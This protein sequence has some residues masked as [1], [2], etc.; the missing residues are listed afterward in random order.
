MKLLRRWLWRVL[1]FGTWRRVFWQKFTDS[2]LTVFIDFLRLIFD[3]ED[4]LERSSDTPT[5]VHVIDS[6][7]V[8]LYMW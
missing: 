7:K 2:L 3:S 5:S 4:E 8:T 1:Y 6:R